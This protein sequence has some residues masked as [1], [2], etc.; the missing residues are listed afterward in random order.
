M[1]GQLVDT[2]AQAVSNR[3]P[4]SMYNQFNSACLQLLNVY[5]IILRLSPCRRAYR[6]T[7]EELRQKLE[8]SSASSEVNLDLIPPLEGS[9]I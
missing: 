7:T 4:N 3:L 9:C 8:L 5:S 6:N 1:R 2:Q